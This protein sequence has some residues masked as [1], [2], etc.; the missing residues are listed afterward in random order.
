M[1]WR[2]EHAL[3]HAQ[4]AAPL[5]LRLEALD[6]SDYRIAGASGAALPTPHRVVQSAFLLALRAQLRSRLPGSLPCSDT[7]EDPIW[8]SVFMSL[9]ATRAVFPY[10]QILQAAFLFSE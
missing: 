9:R 5:A 8:L 6:A 3:R 2:I 4:S 10:S 1:P 7:L